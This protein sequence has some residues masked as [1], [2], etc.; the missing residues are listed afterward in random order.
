ML[1]QQT[2][3]T[4]LGQLTVSSLTLGQL[5]TLPNFWEAKEGEALPE[6]IVRYLPAIHASLRTV[7]Q[8]ITEKQLEDGLTLQDFNALVDAM[9]I[10]AGF[11]AV[12]AGEA[13]APEA[14][15]V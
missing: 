12:P 11:K 8:D 1:K 9:A 6:R 3:Q 15:P 13:Q 4:S 7:H 10:V 5:K 2:V 14:V